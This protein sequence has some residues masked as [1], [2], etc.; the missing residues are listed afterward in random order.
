MKGDREREG[1]KREGVRRGVK[2]GRERE[3]G[4]V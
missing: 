3:Q 2:V 1:V 4:G